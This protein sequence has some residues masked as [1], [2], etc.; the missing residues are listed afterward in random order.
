MAF[1]P[2][3]GN[4]I[5]EGTTFCTNCGTP[6]GA[7]QQQIPVQP[8]PPMV[9]AF[10]PTDHTAEFDPQDISDNKIFAMSAYL[11]GALGIIIALLAGGQSPYAMFHA[12]QS[13]KISIVGILC[14]V[15]MAIPFIGWIIGGIASIV[16]AVIAIICFVQVCKG[17]AKEPAIIKDFKF[18]K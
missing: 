4:Q 15:V 7:P 8:I 5:P 16:I 2:N 14:V 18:L 12:R 3:C 11:L 17:Q 10:D 9:P 1:C 6:V 13:L